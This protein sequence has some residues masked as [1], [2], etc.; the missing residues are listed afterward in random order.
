MA[1]SR[2]QCFIAIRF[3]KDDTDAIYAKMVD[4]VTKLGLRPRRI[5]RIE[6]IENINQKILSELDEAD[7]VLADFTYARPSVYY[8]AGYAQ[9]RIPVIYSCR[10]DHL[11]SREDSLKVHFDVDRYNI[12]FWENPD[13]LSFVPNLES[14]LRTVISDLVRL[15]LVDELNSFVTHLKKSSL[16]PDPFCR[17][18]ESL[19]SQL[20]VYPRVSRSELT[21]E[22]NIEQRLLIYSD[23]F[24][25]INLEFATQPDSEKETQWTRFADVLESEIL[26][27]EELLSYSNYGEIVMYSAHLCSLYRI[28]L[29]SMTKLYQRPSLAYGKKYN[30]VKAA[31]ERLIGLVQNP[32]WP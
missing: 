29:D 7:M 25:M 6:H 4:T 32:I 3:G 27:L 19:F 24:Q 15:P 20:D 11:H 16:N 18:L 12:I 9:R 22:V 13:D 2:I 30:Q 26:Y 5:D 1:T 10:K 14:R 31:I 8:E 28:Y 17:R 23:I 21:H